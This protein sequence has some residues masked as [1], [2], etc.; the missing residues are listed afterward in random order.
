[1]GSGNLASPAPP[2]TREHRPHARRTGS[3]FG[4][5]LTG[6]LP[7][8]GIV[9]SREVGPDATRLQRV[10]R[11]VLDRHWRRARPRTILERR[12]VDGRVGLS[13]E[14][15]ERLGYR[16]WA[17]RH[18]CYI[19]D[20]DGRGVMAA[21]PVGPAWRWERLVL[22]QVLPLAAVLRGMEVLHAS[23]I[24]VGDHAVAFLGRSGAGKTTLAA[25]TVALGARLM[26]DDV[27]AIETSETG[28]DAHRGGA[29]A[30]VD[31][32]QLRQMSRAERTALG[33]VR[34]R[35]EK[36]HVEPTPGPAV[37][38][39]D[40]AYHLVRDA[41]AAGASVVPVRPYD[42]V[43]LLGNLF[44]PHVAPPGRLERQ[45]DVCAA[46]GAAAPLFQVRIG[47]DAGAAAV[48]DSVLEH[49]R[50]LLERPRSP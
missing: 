8:E 14:H 36:W 30:R 44:L 11:P 32:D 7:L 34:A 16:V 26:T 3:A 29:L 18:G 22:S 21:T 48:A 24:A 2:N 43:L 41:A 40:G 1:M 28:V 35:S 10:S 47:P 25:W 39:L 42:P 4:L 50:S 17:P 31:P 27:L 38:P 23:A 6:T 5:S 33:P 12:L 19:V 49:A 46:V 15:D 9:Q 37:L 20:P 45:L 13:V